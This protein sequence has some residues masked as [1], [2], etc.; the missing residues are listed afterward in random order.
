MKVNGVGV[1][2]PVLPVDGFS[3]KAADDVVRNATQSE[4]AGMETGVSR[5]Q[6]N[7][8]ELQKVHKSVDLLNKIMVCYNTE[9]RFTLHKESGEYMIKVVNTSDDNI[10]REIPPK[11]VLDMVAYFKEILGIIV[12][13]FI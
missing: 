3:G 12:D 5:E 11:K 7:E 8:Q 1:S 10:I 2:Q 13:K 4:S 9:V 6:L